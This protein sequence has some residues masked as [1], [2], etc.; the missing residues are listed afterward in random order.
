MSRSKKQR[1]AAKSRLQ[2]QHQARER[3]RQPGAPIDVSVVEPDIHREIRYVTELAQAGDSRI[4]TLGDLVLFSTRTHDAWL[5]DPEDSLAVCLCREGEPQ[6][7]RIIDAPDSLA[8]E[9][10]GE[11][12][13]EGAAFIVQEF[14]GSVVVMHDYPT[15]EISVACRR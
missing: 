2:R 3:R 13:I 4:V 8:I 11:F 15:H 6:P 9:W 7:F 14:S 10:A 12:A 5:L 1:E